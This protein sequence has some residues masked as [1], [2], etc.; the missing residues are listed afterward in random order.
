MGEA[1]NRSDEIEAVKTTAAETQRQQQQ[2]AYMTRKE[3]TYVNAIFLSTAGRM[4]RLVFL[5]SSTPAAPSE[6]RFSMVMHPE[7]F[8]QLLKGG[9][10]LLDQMKAEAEA[11]KAMSV[12]SE[13]IG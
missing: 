13:M 7:D 9:A 3:A 1:K 2:L 5:E 4:V 10:A 12:E 6:P 8:D 11:A